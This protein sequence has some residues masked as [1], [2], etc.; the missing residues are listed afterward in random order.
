MRWHGGQH[1][2]FAVNQVAGVKTRDFEPVPV[3]DGV[4]GTGLHAVTAEDAAVVVDVIDPGVALGPA[5]PVLLGV[6]RSL[7]VDAIR[8]A[9]RGA[10]KTGYAFLQAILVALQHMHTAVALLKHGALQR[11]GTVGI[12]FHDRGLEH[13]PEGDAHAFGDGRDVLKDWHTS[14]VYRKD[15][16]DAGR[17]G[18]L[19]ACRIPVV[20]VRRSRLH[21]G[22]DTVAHSDQENGT[23]ALG[24]RGEECGYIVVEECQAGGAEVLPIRCEIELAAEDAGFE[25]HRAI[26]PIA[27]ALQYGPQVSQEEDVDCGIGGQGLLES[28]VP[29]LGTE[30]SRLQALEQPAASVEDVGSG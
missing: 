25:L 20:R 29:G 9:R 22:F 12:V 5:D 10:E 1:L 11:T 4:G 15:W 27:I 3:G 28:E 2:L 6:L 21:F 13:L 7:D 14:L 23:L 8:G 30:I 18:R 17:S 16:I 26:S 24:V 19:W